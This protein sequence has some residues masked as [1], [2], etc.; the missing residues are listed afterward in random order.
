MTFG[1]VTFNHKSCLLYHSFSQLNLV[2]EGK[3]VVCKLL[4][5]VAFAHWRGAIS[6][7]A[8]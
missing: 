3:Q 4:V 6:F 2:S 1:L 8:D 5:A 7:R